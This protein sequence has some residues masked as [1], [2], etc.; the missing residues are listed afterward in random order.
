MRFKSTHGMGCKACGMEDG[1]RSCRQRLSVA[2]SRA[3][4]VSFS[5]PVSRRRRDLDEKQTAP[6][7]I[8]QHSQNARTMKQD[9]HNVAANTT[10]RLGLRLQPW[11]LVTSHATRCSILWVS[12]NRCSGK[13]VAPENNSHMQ[14]YG[15][16]LR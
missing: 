11:F 6:A 13:F 1:V 16:R 10:R 8:S 12:R 3:V 7:Y 2:N 14:Q 5:P 15:L 4:D 9:R